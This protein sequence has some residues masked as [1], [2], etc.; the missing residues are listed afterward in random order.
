MMTDSEASPSLLPLQVPRR[1]ISTATR[2]CD[3]KKGTVRQ[4][5][6]QAR[7]NHASETRVYT[8]NHCHCCHHHCC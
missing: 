4:V 1:N 3:L 5:R 6:K 2:G 8:S 7:P